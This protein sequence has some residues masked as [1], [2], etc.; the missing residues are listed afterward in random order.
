ML[1]PTSGVVRTLA[2][3]PDKVSAG[4]IERANRLFG[5][6]AWRRVYELRVAGA[7]S[8]EQARAEYV[9]LMRWRL[10]RDL[11]YR[12]T[13]PF[14]IKNTIGGTLYH[15]I[16]ATDNQAGT[17]IMQAI[18]ANAASDFPEMLQ[19]ARDRSRG[20]IAFE[21]GDA[22]L[23]EQQGYRYEPPWEPQGLDVD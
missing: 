10:E 6:T 2:L 4:D 17:E 1:F 9:N 19:E 12:W 8:A 14:E 16:F 3:D 18:Y 22:Y 15:M 11:G 7:I 20:Q 5:T 23:D 21:L 13:H